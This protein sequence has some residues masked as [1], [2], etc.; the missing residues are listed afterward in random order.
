MAVARQSRAS[1]V[2]SNNSASLVFVPAVAV[3]LSREVWQLMAAGVVYG[4]GLG[5][6]LSMFNLSIVHYMGLDNLR[7]TIGILGLA[8]AVG[9]PT[10][11][12]LIGKDGRH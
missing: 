10:L 12:P 3:V 7:P 1:P 8:G 9:F 11:G 4:L 5:F 2:V 6:S